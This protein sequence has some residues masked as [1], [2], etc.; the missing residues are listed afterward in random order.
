MPS[1]KYDVP[2]IM[3]DVLF[4]ENGHAAFDVFRTDG[5]LGDKPTVNRIVQPHL[6]VEPRKYRFR[7]VNGGP[8]RFYEY[9]LSTRDSPFV[10]ISSDGNILPAPVE[11]RKPAPGRGG[12]KRRHHRLLALSARRRNH[13]VQPAWNKIS[14]AGTERAVWSNRERRSSGFDVVPL[15][16]HRTTAGFRRSSGKLPEFDVKR[17]RARENVDL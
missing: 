7:I 8:S 13:H 4:H 16:A 14:G 2:M 12:A 10:V 11:S 17:G 9:Y 5:M 6:K 15:T 1:G 3:H